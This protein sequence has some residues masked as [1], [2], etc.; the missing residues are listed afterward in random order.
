MTKVLVYGTLKSG[1]RNFPLLERA[2]FIKTHTMKAKVEMFDVGFPVLLRANKKVGVM[3]EIYEVDKAT[4][5]RLDRLE[6]NGRMY[7]R[8]RK[9][10]NGKDHKRFW[11]YIG[12]DEFWH[13]ERGSIHRVEPVCD[14]VTWR[15]EDNY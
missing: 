3:G 5:K 15:S 8:V 4:L 12:Q 6:S 7:R 11:V 2:K 1:E 10:L 13:A 14:L 9:R